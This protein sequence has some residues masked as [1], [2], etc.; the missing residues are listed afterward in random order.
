MNLLILIPPTDVES[1]GV[2]FEVPEWPAT[3]S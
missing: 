1:V 2:P 3:V